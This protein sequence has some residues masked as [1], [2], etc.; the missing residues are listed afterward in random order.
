MFSP[1]EHLL[2]YRILRP[3]G[4]GGMG[5]V[6]LAEDERL[7]RMVALKFLPRADSTDP[8][9]RERLR[10]EA[11]ALASLS[12]A[13]IAGIYALEEHQ[14]RLFLVME[15]IEGETLAQRLSRRPL[16]V[17]ELIE[18]ARVLAEALAHAH[19]RGV[20]HRDVKP[21]NILIT[22]EGAT[23]LADFGLALHEGDTRLT[24]EGSTAGTAEHMSPEQT[25]GTALDA[26]SDIFS[27]GV[28][29]YEALTGSR[30][31]ARP[32][33]EATFHAI[34]AEDPEAPTSLRSGIPLELER[35]IMKCLRKDPGAR[36]QHAE[37]LAADLRAL[38]SATATGTTSASSA[39]AE[40]PTRSSRR[41]RSLLLV[42]PALLVVVALAYLLSGLRP[43]ANGKGEAEA[44][45]RSI[46]VLSFQNMQDPNDTKREAIMA[47]SLLT[48]GLG[49]SQVIPV[50]GAQR[51]HD[52][53]RQMGKADQPVTGT[54]ALDVGRR[55]GASYVVTGYIYQTQPDVVLA[56]EI[57]S[58]AD[59]SVLTS[60]RVSAAGGEQGLFAA[61]DSLTIALRDG[62]AQAGFG[63]K[64]NPID[65]AAATTHSPAAYRAYVRGL[66]Q[67][68]RGHDGEAAKAFQSAVEADSTFALAWY[69]L[70]VATWWNNDFPA[71]LD[72]V[73]TALR[74][75]RRLGDRDREG[76]SALGLLVQGKYDA[77]IAAYQ[78]LTQRYPQEKELHYGLGEALYHSEKDPAATRAALNRAIELDP[79]FAVAYVHVI[80][81]DV[82]QGNLRAALADAERLQRADPTNPFGLELKMA[83]LG[84]LGDPDGALQVSR[85]I[86][87]NHPEAEEAQAKHFMLLLMNG[88]PDSSRAVLDRVVAQGLPIDPANLEYGRVIILYSE[89]RFQE[90]ERESRKMI[91]MLRPDHSV[92]VT[93]NILTL[94]S[95]AL[96]ASGRVPEAVAA[97][98]EQFEITQ[99]RFFGRGMV[100]GTPVV[101]L[102]C[103]AGH[104]EMAAPVI[105][106]YD[107]IIAE[108]NLVLD[109]RARDHA[110]ARIALAEK[111]PRD[112]MRL[113]Q[114]GT[115]PGPAERGQA[116]RN[117]VLARALLALGDRVKAK[118]TLRRAAAQATYAG[119]PDMLFSSIALLA[120][121]EER[122]GR[123]DEALSLY[124]RVAHQYRHADPGFKLAEEARAGVARMERAG[125]QAAAD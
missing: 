22:P 35:I 42:V 122:D 2:H 97:A 100:L 118:E 123:K 78:R 92:T 95:R 39:H 114:T 103:D 14:D 4:A 88:Q 115:P 71:A 52:V 45:Q 18:R 90:A 73:H 60:R 40:A 23:K 119:E 105:R 84:R 50:L 67:L 13:G 66:D 86:I 91:Q 55:A 69:Q 77:A 44:A 108:R 25:H 68:Y 63:V 117:Y 85:E 107:R 36:Y 28:V 120:R 6:F 102:F 56:A 64:S 94:R 116:S 112:A 20:I 54:D 106:A 41:K 93:V 111:R 48:V 80:D 62:L 82:N 12:H 75:G 61:V 47:T 98:K 27:L 10:R 26:R 121:E 46:A 7:G 76:L 65:L 72:E 34:R 24:A 31:F 33:L 53:L 110:L 57:A 1:G 49:Q 87:A 89:G 109:R 16:P 59:G 125:A 96:L 9:R 43:G 37:D 124:R 32:T 5:E 17:P 38:A 83:A 8:E 51:V 99:R 21:S 81:V 70:A 113:I 104:P 29:L 19:G 58:T 3:L 74:L 30:P 11:R 15:Y 79:T 101:Q